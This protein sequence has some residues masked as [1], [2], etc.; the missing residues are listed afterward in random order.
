ME[1]MA[2]FAVAQIEILAIGL[3]E[4]LHEFAQRGTAAF[5]QQVDMVG[6]E[7]IGVDGIAVALAVA[8]QASQIGPVVGFIVKGLASLVAAD[9]HV[10][11]QSWGK[12]SGAAGHDAKVYRIEGEGVKTVML[13][14]SDPFSDPFSA[15]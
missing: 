4:A 11:E 13:S 1:Y 6:H 7:T 12:Q 5:H 15:L 2:D 14:K 3:L 9:D 8:G 10:V